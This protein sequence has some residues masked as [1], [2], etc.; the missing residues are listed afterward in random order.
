MGSL[1]SE[2]YPFWAEQHGADYDW[3]GSST[4]SPDMNS[5][6]RGN[7]R[8]RTNDAAAEDESIRSDAL[9]LASAMMVGA[10][11]DSNRAI[12]P[13]QVAE[14]AL[15]HYDDDDDY[16]QEDDLQTSSI[17]QEEREPHNSHHHSS[18]LLNS[19]MV[20]PPARIYTTS[21]ATHSAP[22]TKA[23]PRGVMY[24]GVPHV[25][26]DYSLVPDLPDYSRKKTGGVSQPFPEKLH[27][28]LKEVEGTP[29]A[30]IVSWLTHG[31]AFIVKSP[32]Q[33]TE[34]IMPM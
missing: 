10:E 12:S 3:L 11:H 13:S 26:H 21:S 34:R 17:T 6:A 25:Y 24:A 16:D 29:D 8:R 22:T 15:G 32:K 14:E 30:D 23:K 18:V 4:I 2:I 28:M 31:R 27:E 5:A 1:S 9:V 19:P 20:T 33:F 7:R